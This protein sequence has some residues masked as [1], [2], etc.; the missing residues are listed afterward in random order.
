[1]SSL[2]ETA[3]RLGFTHER[4]AR[5]LEQCQNIARHERDLREAP[6]VDE[7]K[8]EKIR[9]A[10][11]RLIDAVGALDTGE[12]KFV[13]AHIMTARAMCPV[14]DETGADSTEPT[15]RDIRLLASETLRGSAAPTLCYKLRNGGVRES[16]DG[17]RV[18]VIIRTALAYQEIAGCEP[19]IITDPGRNEPLGGDFVGLLLDVA[20]Q[21]GLNTQ[22]LARAAKRYLAE[23]EV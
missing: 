12:F 10:A 11:A 21:I 16:R 17:A 1:M 8:I 14:A 20:E 19:T 4:Y 23:R 7:Q 9:K 15:W 6:K 3:K 13:S 2:S 5:L 22:G 18:L